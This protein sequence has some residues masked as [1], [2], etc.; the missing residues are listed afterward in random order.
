MVACHYLVIIITLCH[1]DF[2]MTLI[3]YWFLTEWDRENLSALG[4][5]FLGPTFP[6]ALILDGGMQCSH[7]FYLSIFY[8]SLS[9]THWLFPTPSEKLLIYAPSHIPLPSSNCSLTR[10]PD[11]P[12]KRGPKWQYSPPKNCYRPPP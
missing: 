3:Q 6:M 7:S 12:L 1:I 11:T 5:T 10:P 9:H 4:P 2:L 8:L